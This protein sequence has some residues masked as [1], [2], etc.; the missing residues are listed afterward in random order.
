MHQAS[1]RKILPDSQ[2]IFPHIGIISYFFAFVK[3]FL[4]LFH[5][6]NKILIFQIIIS[7][8]D[9]GAHK[10]GLSRGLQKKF[11]IFCD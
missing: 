5:N 2:N 10:K 4:K 3:P 7:D 6:I 8:L 1:F 9:N 11:Q